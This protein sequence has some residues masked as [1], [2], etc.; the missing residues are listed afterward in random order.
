M[1]ESPLPETPPLAETPPPGD[2]VTTAVMQD[3]VMAAGAHV[4]SHTVTVEG[5]EPS[6]LAGEAEH[7]MSGENA[8][9]TEEDEAEQRERERIRMKEEE[10]AKR[11]QV[12]LHRQPYPILPSHF[13]NVIIVI[14]MAP[15]STHMSSYICVL[16]AS[17]CERT[18]KL[19]IAESFRCLS[20]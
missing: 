14:C 10:D 6:R 11:C 19:A 4:T 9:Q 1:E 2:H 18:V 3:H 5:L 15:F 17:V 8:G 20:V 13:V 16:Q 12:P 7:V